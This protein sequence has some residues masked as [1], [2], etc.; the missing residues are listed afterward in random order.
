MEKIYIYMLGGFEIIVNNTKVIEQ[1][2]NSKKRVT[3]LEYLLLNK[4]KPAYNYALIDIL[5][6]D[7][8]GANPESALK[9]LVSRLRS[10]LAE[11]SS[12]LGNCI[13]TDKGSYRWN[14]ALDCE[15][16]VYE[17]EHLCGVLAEVSEFTPA[18][19]EKFMRV[20]TLYKGDL[21]PNSSLQDW[22][23]SRSIYLH[24]VYLKTI[25]RFIA[26]LKAENDL[27]TV[28]EVCRAALDVDIFDE[29]LHLEL[30]SALVKSGRNNAA[31]VQYKC[32]TNL[33]YKHLGVEP[34]EKLIDFYKELIKAD[35]AA[36]TDINTIRKELEDSA[37]T[38]GAFV[39]DYSIFKDIYKLQLRNLERLGCPIFIALVTMDNY[40]SMDSD[41][42]ELEKIMND[43]LDT[44]QAVLRKGDTVARYSSTQYA[45]I[46]PNLTAEN[47]NI[48]LDRIRWSFYKKYVNS[49]VRL[50]FQL[51]PM[52]LGGK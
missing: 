28:V 50:T 15:I 38:S 42:L 34:S 5:W 6:G 48:V 8:E 14:P 31:L 52:G 18:V 17:F 39:C 47:G 41:P 26:F 49:S 1:L 4:D 43:L 24:N 9:T 51:G 21:L 23:V 11:Y 44:L 25:H 3:L 10:G 2:G 7:E 27:E 20:I 29:T 45:L 40:L 46:L 12:A 22:V 35:L 32:A 19:K 33:Y 36:E 30:M 37:D 16:D 13:L